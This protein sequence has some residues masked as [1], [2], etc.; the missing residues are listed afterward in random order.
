M[1]KDSAAFYRML[2]VFD[3]Q[4]N[5]IKIRRDVYRVETDDY[6]VFITDKVYV[7]DGKTITEI[8]LVGRIPTNIKSL[9]SG[10]SNTFLMRCEDKSVYYCMIEHGL[11][12]IRKIRDAHLIQNLV[13]YAEGIYRGFPKLK[14]GDSLAAKRKMEESVVLYVL[15]VDTLELVPIGKADI[16]GAH[17]HKVKTKYGIVLISSCIKK[18]IHTT[19]LSV[20]H[21][22]RNYFYDCPMETR[23]EHIHVVTIRG[24]DNIYVTYRPEYLYKNGNKVTDYF[25]IMEILEIHQ[26]SVVR[27]Q[28]SN[29]DDIGCHGY[30]LYTTPSLTYTLIQNPNTESGEP[31]NGT[32]LKSKYIRSNGFKYETGRVLPV[33]N[34]MGTYLY[35]T[36]DTLCLL[37]WDDYG[38]HTYLYLPTEPDINN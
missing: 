15:D 28:I 23:I 32:F 26:F 17:V 11:L 27:K 2:E 22:N 30:I 20:L 13:Q 36:N 34:Q 31:I 14:E 10:F 29:K 8:R 7:S 21:S 25:R 4:C 18:A 12:S 16:N 5:D 35:S 19:T 37:A 1:P 9:L 3:S 38:N 6:T 33:S 24:I